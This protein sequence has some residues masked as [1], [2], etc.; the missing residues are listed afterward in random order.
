MVDFEVACF[1]GL[2]VFD[3]PRMTT[4]N[5]LLVYFFGAR[6]VSFISS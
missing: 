5:L 4:N 2:T 6:P 1:D 3:A